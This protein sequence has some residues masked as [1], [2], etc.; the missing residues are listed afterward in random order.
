M[1]DEKSVELKSTFEMKISIEVFRRYL[2]VVRS[3]SLV[4]LGP[5]M[6]HEWKWEWSGLKLKFCC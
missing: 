6:M 1:S 3:S 4:W 2:R 5:V